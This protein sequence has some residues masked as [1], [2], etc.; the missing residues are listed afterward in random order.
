MSAGRS[1][2]AT[3]HHVALQT[4]LALSGTSVARQVLL[5]RLGEDH[6][7]EGIADAARAHGHRARVVQIAPRELAHL[8]LPTLLFLEGGTAAVIVG[9][10]RRAVELLV[11]GDGPEAKVL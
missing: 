11:G 2:D 7:P 5:E 8:P 4:L 3:P 9:V 10:R 6:T 1:W